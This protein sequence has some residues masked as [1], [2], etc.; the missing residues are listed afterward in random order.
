MAAGPAANLLLAVLFYSVVNWTGV[1][2]PAAILAPPQAES[3]AA[4]AGLAGGE[5]VLRA[6][7]D[8]ESE[9]DVKSFE[10]LRWQLTRGARPLSALSG[11]FSNCIATGE[12]TCSRIG[13]LI[14]DSA[15]SLGYK[16]S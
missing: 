14:L 4:Q 13:N 9:T 2:L 10:D 5:R 8:G 3:L 15:R 7:L 6:G 1:Q 12:T 11:T 16:F